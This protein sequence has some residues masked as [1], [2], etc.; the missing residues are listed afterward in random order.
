MIVSL[1]VLFEVL[2]IILCLHYL[3]GKK[4]KFD[5]ITICFILFDIG[6][7]QTISIL[8]INHSWSLLIYPVIILYCGIKF[9]FE[10]K[11]III[12]N[13]VYLI[14][15][16]TLQYGIT[17]ILF[18]FCGIEN[19]NELILLGGNVFIFFFV[20]VI[21]KRCNLH[22]LSLDLQSNARIIIL[23]IGVALI[24]MLFCLM[25][26]KYNDGLKL[27][28]YLLLLASI[29]LICVSAV[30]IGRQRIKAKEIEAELRMH[31]I[32]DKSFQTLI[33]NI[34]ARQ[35]EFDNHLNTIYAQ[36]FLCNS[37][38]ELVEKQKKYCKEVVEDNKYNRLLSKGK[39][40]IIGFLYGKFL[41]AEK[42]NLKVQYH[43][44]IEK[45]H[46]DIPEYKL[47]EIIGNLLNNAMEELITNGYRDL[48][49]NLVE[50]KEYILIEVGNECEKVDY[51][52]IQ[53]IFTK[54]YSKKGK[55]RGLG[56]YNVKKICK[57]Y[58]IGLLCFNRTDDMRNWLVF[59]LKVNKSS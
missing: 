34:R 23:I 58:D 7:M 59:S 35:H 11:E 17:C 28:Y 54:G 1:Y 10:I 21:I 38:D 31:E 39:H 40:S 6:M 22:K 47:V 57:E 36:H 15:I 13:L 49:V 8:N 32:Y 14:I 46:C 44:S 2:S 42:Q 26:F 24:C 27:Q 53:N 50:S 18:L 25:E 55:T 45:L 41:E 16:G 43:V 5:V 33:E 12:N 56:L 51:I 48:Y 9:G 4:V 19:I 52:E 29:I 30:D 20:A 3:Y 37:Y